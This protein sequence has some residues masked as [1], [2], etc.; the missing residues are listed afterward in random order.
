MDFF[1]GLALFWHENLVVDV[2]AVTRDTSISMSGYLWMNPSW[3]LTCV[4]SN[5][6]EAMWL[7]GYFSAFVRPE[8]QMIAS[9]DTLEICELVDIGFSRVT[10][11][12][13]NK[14]RG[15][16]NVKVRMDIDV[17]TNA[18]CSIFVEANVVH[19]VSLYYD[20]TP[21]LLQYKKEEQK[22]FWLARKHYEIISIS[23]GRTGR[24]S[25]G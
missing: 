18:W 5:F 17:V 23:D 20:H 7:F 25:L 10:F 3:C 6:N 11:T 9:R 24:K 19:L 2:K 13:D 16:G 1:G 15:R 22:V 21:I 14:R 4:Y 12:Y 8:Q